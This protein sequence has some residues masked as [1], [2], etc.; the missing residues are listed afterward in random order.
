MINKILF[1]GSQFIYIIF[2][3][4]FQMNKETQLTSYIRSKVIMHCKS[5]ILI[6]HKNLV[7]NMLTLTFSMCISFNNHY[8]PCNS[9]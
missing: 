3:V 5:K 1:Y 2:K 8:I 6:I 4:M 9:Q 7:F